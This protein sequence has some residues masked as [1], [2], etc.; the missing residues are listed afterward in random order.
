MSD[1]QQGF[2]NEM[3]Q[4]R[5]RLQAVSSLALQQFEQA[6]RA[7]Q[8]WDSRLA[9]QALSQLQKAHDFEQAL[10]DHCLDIL[11]HTSK[12][13]DLRLILALLKAITD[14]EQICIQNSQIA[15]QVLVPAATLPTIKQL[16]A[17]S[18]L[19]EPVAK[20]LK[21]SLAALQQYNISQAEQVHRYAASV[22]SCYGAILR[23]NLTTGDLESGQLEVALSINWVARAL[24]RIAE[25]CINLAKQAVFLT[26][27][28]SGQSLRVE[29]Q[30]RRLR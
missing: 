16:Q 20:M 7:Y 22:N 29:L 6:M 4:A 19:A 14:I 10:D 25:H 26:R 11:S 15:Q 8:T 27:V 23:S 5:H 18:A 3:Q 28:S 21:L 13:T 2:K 17:I 9:Q 24:E 30:P 1:Q 12:D